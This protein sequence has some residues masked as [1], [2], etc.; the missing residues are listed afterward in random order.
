M[1]SVVT[2]NDVMTCMDVVSASCAVIIKKHPHVIDM[3]EQLFICYCSNKVLFLEC[4]FRVLDRLAK[5]Q[6]GR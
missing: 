2:L 5:I 3:Y 6:G 4:Y 1:N